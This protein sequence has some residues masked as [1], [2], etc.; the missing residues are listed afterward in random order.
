VRAVGGWLVL[1]SNG[2]ALAE[3]LAAGV[4]LV[5]PSLRELREL[6]GQPLPDEASWRDAARALIAK[7]QAQIV[8][9]SLGEDGPCS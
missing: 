6:T 8:A 7:G 2:A 9:L 5:K 1:D 3:T 4:Y